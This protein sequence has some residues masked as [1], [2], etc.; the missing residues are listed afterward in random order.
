M[1]RAVIRTLTLC[2]MF[3]VLNCIDV[4]AQGNFVYVFN[5]GAGTVSAFSIDANGFLTTVAGSPFPTG[6]FD[7]GGGFIGVRAITTLQT[8][9]H[10]FVVNDE[11]HNISTLTINPITG[12]LTPVVGSPF[13]TGL[14]LGSQSSLAATPDGRFLYQ[15]F[16]GGGAST[17][18]A[19]KIGLDGSL[20]V[21]PG[22]PLR[23]GE[24]FSV[25]ISPDGRFLALA[26]WFHRSIAIYRIN[27]DG[28]LT[29]APH[30]PFPTAGSGLSIQVEFNCAG[31]LLFGSEAGRLS[32]GTVSGVSAYHVD[33]QGNLTLVPGSPFITNFTGSGSLV[34]S[35]DEKFL[36][37]NGG[38]SNS[39]Y[40][41]AVAPNGS[42]SPV[43]GSPFANPET[44]SSV[45]MAL[46][47]AGTLLYVLNFGFG[48]T[49]SIYKV[50]DNGALTLVAGAP[51][52]IGSGSLPS[53]AAYP[54]KPC[55]SFGNFDICIQDDSSGSIVRINSTTGDYQFANCSGFT[56]SG[57]GSLIKRG[58]IVT[59]QDYAA[60]RRVLA[61]ID[62]S[63]NRGTASIQVFSQGSTFTITD[64]NTANNTCACAA[65]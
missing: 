45:G 36:F 54:P 56:L 19:Y 13:S 31:N 28:A 24:T 4:N 61:R 34:L 18:A 53:L 35:L 22:F 42:L 59:L 60:D 5:D 30:S 6:G 48:E 50:A 3:L 40:A 7:G 32:E 29:E 47:R 20:T 17:L 16:L 55:S 1:I 11:N 39:V 26:Q 58:G 62:E 27:S 49:I 25:Q 9:N 33:A 51:F 46:N 52:F 37:L 57:M 43:P 21:L 23:I 65:H 63:V 2:C 38:S 12:V 41:F 10:L 15:A 64:R 44:F 8:G 14:P